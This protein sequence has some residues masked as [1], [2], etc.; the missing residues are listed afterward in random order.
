MHLASIFVQRSRYPYTCP[1]RIPNSPSWQRTR[2]IVSLPWKILANNIK[3]SHDMF[4][5]KTETMYQLGRI[6]SSDITSLSSYLSLAASIP[7]DLPPKHFCHNTSK[8]GQHITYVPLH[9]R[10]L[11][12]HFTKVYV[13]AT[14]VSY[15]TLVNLLLSYIWKISNVLLFFL[16]DTSNQS[17][18]LSTYRPAHV[19]S[20]S[21][22]AYH[23]L[24]SSALINQFLALLS[25]IIFSLILFW[26]C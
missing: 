26:T 25:S 9:I 8:S 24:V 19:V 12:S 5:P 23:L 11:I 3:Y 18:V 14:A 1:V 17:S 22:S 10:Q 21:S 16:I 7:V 4:S 20:S 6:L 2:T 15:P 13:S